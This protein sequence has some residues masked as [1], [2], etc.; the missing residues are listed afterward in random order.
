MAIVT[1][2]VHEFTLGDI[3]DPA[4][5]AAA[6]LWD[7]QQS[8]VGKWVMEHAVEIPQWGQSNDYR[9][10]S[11]RFRV[12]AKFKEQ[13]ATFFKLKYDNSKAS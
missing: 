6:P 4:I 5:Y 8:E 10:Y 11:Y 2:V 12:T 7:W 9:T 1:L 3:D 13:D